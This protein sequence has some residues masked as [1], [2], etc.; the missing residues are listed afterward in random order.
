M[1]VEVISNHLLLSA[2]N[3]L[4]SA[5]GFSNALRLCAG[6]LDLSR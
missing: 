4:F 3:S 2:I 1:A 5:I 6:H